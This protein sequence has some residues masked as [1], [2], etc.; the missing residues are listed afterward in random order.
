MSEQGRAAR[1]RRRS[2]G[3]R[4]IDHSVSSPCIA[5]CTIDDA[6]GRCAGCFRTID[7]IRDWPILSRE[8]KLAVLDLLAERRRDGS[9]S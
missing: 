1:P 3:R 6:N 8:E 7:E 2:R 5:V 9:A 4:V